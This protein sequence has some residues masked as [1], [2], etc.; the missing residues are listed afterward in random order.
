MPRSG[1]RPDRRFVAVNTYSQVEIDALK[2]R[3]T[4]KGSA[5]HKLRPGDYNLHPPTNPRGSKSP[6]DDLRTVLLEE[7][8]RL[9]IQGIQLQLLSKFE[10]GGN[11]KYVWSVDDQGEPYEAKES[12]SD[13][14]NYHG[15]RLSD[16]DYM[17]ELVLAEWKRRCPKD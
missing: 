13:P 15:Y 6:C 3:I 7:A 11:P 16:D 17:R 4:Y 8:T 1:N 10:P 14:Q 12:K 9:L 2:Q 5:H